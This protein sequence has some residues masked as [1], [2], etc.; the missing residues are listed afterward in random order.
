VEPRGLEPLTP[1]LQSRSG[2]IGE[3]HLRGS[4]PTWLVAQS[5]IIAGAAAVCCCR[6]TETDRCLIRWARQ[7]GAVND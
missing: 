3:P 1:C 6:L 5:V 2:A 4:A 7:A